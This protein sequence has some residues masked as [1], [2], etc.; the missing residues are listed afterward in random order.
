MA[1]FSSKGLFFAA[2]PSSEAELESLSHDVCHTCSAGIRR[3]SFFPSPAP[4]C[5]DD[6]PALMGHKLTRDKRGEE[7]RGVMCMREEILHRN[8]NLP[9]FP[10]EVL[11]SNELHH[12][13][14]ACC[15]MGILGGCVCVCVSGQN[16][17]F[18]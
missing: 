6:K 15:G 18:T 5:W 4:S 1:R 9:A 7:E 16:V 10:R 11:E 17:T 13:R 8:H 2:A 12:P 3:P 14:S